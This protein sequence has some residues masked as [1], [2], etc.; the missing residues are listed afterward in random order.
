[1]TFEATLIRIADQPR[2]TPA[3]QRVGVPTAHD[4]AA[5]VATSVRDPQPNVH[6][7]QRTTNVRHLF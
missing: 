2:E 5:G 7:T 3:R 4:L 1:M 6:D